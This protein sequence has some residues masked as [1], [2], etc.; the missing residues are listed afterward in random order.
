MLPAKDLGLTTSMEVINQ[1]VS[2]NGKFVIDAG[3]GDLTFSRPLLEQGARVLA[4]DPDPVQAELNRSADPVENLEFREAGA[5]R[6]PV[7]D[8]TVDGIFFSYSLHHIPEAV[9]GQVFD[10]VFRVLRPDGFLCVIEPTPCPLNDVMKLFHNED[11]ER[12]AAQQAIEQI[13]IP[14]FDSVDVVAYH[15]FVEYESFDHF[16]KRFASK[17]FNTI[18][19]ESDVRKSAVREAFER[20]GAPDYRF[21]SPKQAVML[22]NLRSPAK[23]SED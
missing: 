6:L 14:A 18:Y 21:Q 16:A 19:T 10:E 15:S 13:A 20:V 7:K 12:A 9:Y 4:I 1:Y 5:D 23:G 2:L 17:S 8:G 11:R 3:C 22:R